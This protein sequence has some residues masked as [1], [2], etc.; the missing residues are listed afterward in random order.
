LTKYFGFIAIKQAQDR[1]VDKWTI[2]LL[3]PHTNVMQYG[4]PHLDYQ[5]L[6]GP[7]IRSYSFCSDISEQ[8]IMRVY[9]VQEVSLPPPK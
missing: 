2:I 7:E 6:E 4:T 5:N 1:N 9:K 3:R 8:H